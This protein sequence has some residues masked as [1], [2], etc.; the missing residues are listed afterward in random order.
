MKNL[1]N[2]LFILALFGGIS[3]KTFA[4]DEPK[5]QMS[6]KTA[7]ITIAVLNSD[8]P[9]HVAFVRYYDKNGDV[10]LNTS[11]EFKIDIS[12]SPRFA[13]GS[14]RRSVAVP[15]DAD[16]FEVSV[17]NCTNMHENR[18]YIKDLQQNKDEVTFVF[19]GIVE[20]LV[21]I[22][23]IGI[24]DAKPCTFQ[25]KGA[26]TNVIF[27][28]DYSN[29]KKALPEESKNKDISVEISE[30]SLYKYKIEKVEKDKKGKIVRVNV[31]LEK[32]EGSK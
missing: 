22:E 23:F 29:V 8:R 6:D 10:V 15:K 19:R 17:T 30:T 20:D 3:T 28:A 7:T 14:I 2:I 27:Y 21:S 24:Q 1:V 12:K 11:Q 32:E 4:Q 31:S 25:I 26:N 13:T 5:E 18:F 9:Y 16:Y